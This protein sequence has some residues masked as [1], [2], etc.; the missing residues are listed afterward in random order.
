MTGRRPDKASWSS[1]LGSVVA[2]RETR[3]LVV[4]T[5]R[6]N[7]SEAAEYRDTLTAA[8]HWLGALD[9]L[10]DDGAVPE[11]CDHRQGKVHCRLDRGHDCGHRYYAHV[12]EDPWAE[13]VPADQLDDD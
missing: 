5:R 10:D 6:V 9:D 1:P 12:S 8:L 13:A 3:Q 7:P 4:G 2:I 11:P